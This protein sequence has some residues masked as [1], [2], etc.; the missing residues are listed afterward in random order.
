[1]ARS[2]AAGRVRD[3][4]R[5]G[6]KALPGGKVGLAPRSG[7]E[8][9]R[10]TDPAVVLFRDELAPLGAR[11]LAARHATGV[12][13]P[14]IGVDLPALGIAAVTEYEEL[15]A[16][17][18]EPGADVAERSRERSER[19]ARRDVPQDRVPVACRRGERPPVGGELRAEHASLVASQ[20]S[21]GAAAARDV[22]QLR[23]TLMGRDGEQSA[24]G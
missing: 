23:V 13:R 20:A 24:V 9:L 3:M 7:W 17:R 22:P 12:L 1:M 5:S 6:P 14:G 18:R 21:A 19:A 16:V 2:S 10:A 11:Q 15:P 4:G 8:R